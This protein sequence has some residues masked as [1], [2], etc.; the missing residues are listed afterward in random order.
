MTYGQTVG[1]T[2]NSQLIGNHAALTWGLTGLF[3]KGGIWIGLGSV[4]LGMGLSGS[5]YRPLEMALVLITLLAI[6]FVGVWIIN[7]PFD[8]ARHVLPHFYFSADW[9]WQP[10][11]ELKPRPEC[12]GGLLL[13]LICL[14]AYVQFGRRDR[15]A[16]NLGLIGFLAGG[17]GF[18][19]G[20]SIQAFHAWHSDLFTHSFFAPLEPH[21]NWWNMM[22]ITFGATFG[23]LLA[24]GV[25]LNHPLISGQSA[26]DKV[27]LSPAWEWSLVILYTALLALAEFSNVAAWGL[28]LEYGLAIGILPVVGI[29]GGRD[30]PYLFV[31]PIVALP[32]AG[33]TLA[34]LCYKNHVL[35]RP[36][37]WVILLALPLVLSTVAAIWLARRGRAGERSASLA[38]W[39]LLL[40][41]WIYYG[42]NFAFFRCPWPWQK[43]TGRTPSA[44]IFTLCAVSLTVAAFA[45]RDRSIQ[46]Q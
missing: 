41:A 31:L 13:A 42:L 17:I 2:Q 20:Q 6:F 26:N 29:L 12:W 28:L 16:R 37:G 33:K 36:W 8:P 30:W 44:L 7:H 19:G 23:G 5:R 4:F 21:M 24:A 43:W 18:A 27:V 11:A 46:Q 25:W 14:I 1:L 32:I 34:E 45:V 39:G 35:S 9:H 15:L 10:E 38:R 3:V 40:A 22:E